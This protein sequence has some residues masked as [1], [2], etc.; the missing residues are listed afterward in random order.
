MSLP[1][2]EPGNESVQTRIERAGFWGVVA[3]S[4]FAVFAIIVMC[5]CAS[6]GPQIV[7]I[8]V[9]TP[10]YC[11][12]SKLGRDPVYPDTDQALAAVADPFTAVQLLTMGRLD[13]IQR[14]HEKQAALDACAGPKPALSKP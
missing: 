7:K 13:R 10:V 5:S 3:M 14:D 9:P 6:S 11:D 2:P 8:P 4:I 12:T 1:W